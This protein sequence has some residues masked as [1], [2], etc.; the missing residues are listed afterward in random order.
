MKRTAK[1]VKARRTKMKRTTK[2]RRGTTTRDLGRAFK[3]KARA[4]GIGRASVTG[5]R[6]ADDM[7]NNNSSGSFD[8]TDPKVAALAY[9]ARGLAI[10]PLATGA[11]TPLTRNGCKSASKDAQQITSWW[12][13]SPDANVGIATGSPSLNLVVIDVDRKANGV[14]GDDALAVLTAA[15][16][17]L[18]TTWE[19]KTGGGGRHIYFT[20]PDG[21]TVKNRIGFVPGVD[22]RGEDG[23][24]VGPPSVHQSGRRYAWEVSHHPDEVPIARLPGWLFDLLTRTGSVISLAG[25][26]QSGEERFFEGRRNSA[27][28]SL[29]GTMRRRGMPE[30]AILAALV[31]LNRR[32]CSPPLSG[33]EVAKIA[34][35]IARYAPS[36]SP[37]HGLQVGRPQQGIRTVCLSEVE[38]H[39]RVWL[40][41]ARIPMGCIS[42]LEG[43]PCV[44]KTTLALAVAAAA[45][46]GLSLPGGGSP[47][48]APMNVLMCSA[49]DAADTLLPRAEALG[50]DRSRIH[51]I[52]ERLPVLPDDIEAIGHRIADLRAGVL[53]LDPFLAFLAA[54]INSHRD[55]DV[56]RVLSPLAALADRSGVAILL[57]RHLNKASGQSA[58]NRGGGSI[59]II[60]ASRSALLAGRDPR[61]SGVCVLAS[62]KCNLSRAPRSLRYRL[63]ADGD[64]GAARIAWLDESDHSADDLVSDAAGERSAREEAR[65]FLCIELAGGSVPGSEI[66]SRARAA[67]IAEITLRRAKG[68]LGVR[69]V[70][71]GGAGGRWVWRMPLRKGGQSPG[72]SILA[73]APPSVIR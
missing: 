58:I 46:R 52:T 31:V 69:S 1:T 23:Y 29:A 38:Q 27:L 59:G 64:H 61:E 8:Q 72:V 10:L 39:E 49:E 68:D 12:T 73:T 32:Q 54:D 22:V 4:V 43:E 20:T 33:E 15:F 63:E 26:G 37:L 9:A 6:S 66:F 25:Q 51:V 21:K 44:G 42:L 24:V 28:A 70:K 50:A 48:L 11:K 34:R 19:V 13:K 53:I 16:G 3:N 41:N 57:L 36:L 14:D 55:Q 2:T 65:E 40:W 35:S 45:T 18:P 5:N 62:V 17:D 47:G 60:G 7:E 67:G 56:R 30:E 71:E